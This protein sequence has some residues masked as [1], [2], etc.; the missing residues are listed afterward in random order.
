MKTYNV[1]ITE[2]LKT[3]IEVEAK[4]RF[5]AEQLVSDGWHRG[6]YILDAE[7]FVGVNFKAV[8]PERDRGAR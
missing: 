7:C 3:T 4:D 1:T 5:E 2:T 6:D 8:L